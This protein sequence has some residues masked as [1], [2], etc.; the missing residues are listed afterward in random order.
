M[1][2]WLLS[3]S[4]KWPKKK[5][6]E[7]IGDLI[8]F[9]SCKRALW[10]ANMPCNNGISWW[11]SLGV[12][13]STFNI[14][15]ELFLCLKLAYIYVYTIS[16]MASA[17]GWCVLQGLWSLNPPPIPSENNAAAC[18]R[19]LAS[20]KDLA[21]PLGTAQAWRQVLCQSKSVVAKLMKF[22]FKSSSF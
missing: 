2:V 12:G 7:D 11:C 10:Q 9:Q 6:L 22:T 3:K 1:E 8:I 21:V 14:L 15:V 13:V 16:S 19:S 17:L 5:V 20:A 4:L 18:K